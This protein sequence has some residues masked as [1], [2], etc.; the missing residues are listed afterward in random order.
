MDNLFQNC[1]PKMSDGRIFKD[2]KTATRRNEQIKYVNGVYRD[3]EYRAMLQQNGADIMKR[4]A[5]Y[6]KRECG[7]VCVHDNV[8]QR[9]SPEQMA[10]Q[11]AR[12]NARNQPDAKQCEAKEPYRM[13]EY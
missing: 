1:H 11:M 13:T 3:D 10:Q 8:P 5:A 7:S 4:T 9:V 6:Y 12:Y 2:N